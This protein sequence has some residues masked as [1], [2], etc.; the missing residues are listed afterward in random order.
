[1]MVQPQ[2]SSLSYD[3]EQLVQTHLA[4]EKELKPINLELLLETSPNLKEIHDQFADLMNID[5]RMRSSL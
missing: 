2:I 5:E 3:I 1:M 4:P